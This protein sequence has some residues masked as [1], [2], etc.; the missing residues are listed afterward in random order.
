MR[1]SIRWWTSSQDAPLQPP[2]P[3]TA[4]NIH[5]YIF[6]RR[7]FFIALET[8]KEFHSRPTQKFLDEKQIESVW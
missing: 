1:T 6:L 8:I 7:T 5:I 4:E 3:K 2:S